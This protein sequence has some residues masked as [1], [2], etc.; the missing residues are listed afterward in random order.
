MVQHGD[1]Q[2]GEDISEKTLVEKRHHQAN[3]EEDWVS[4]STQT[5]PSHVENLI[6][7]RPDRST[8]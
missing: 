8:K 4:L 1:V 3:R 6:D 7:S 2:E 5:H